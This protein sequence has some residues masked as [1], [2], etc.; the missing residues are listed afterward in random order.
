MA[1]A[2]AA[3]ALADGLTMA[4]VSEPDHKRFHERWPEACNPHSQLQA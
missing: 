3:T 1:I 4:F 2:I